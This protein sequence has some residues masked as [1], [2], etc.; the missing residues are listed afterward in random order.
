MKPHP[1]KKCPFCGNYAKIFQSQEY[2][3]IHCMSDF[4]LAGR[5]GYYRSPEEAIKS[6][7]KRK[8][9]PYTRISTNTEKPI[10]L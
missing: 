4:C 6:W 1:A 2:W 3:S 8:K 10:I 9:R 7:N 5:V